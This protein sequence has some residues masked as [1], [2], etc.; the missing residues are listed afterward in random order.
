MNNSRKSPSSPSPRRRPTAKSTF[1]THSGSDIKLNRSLGD[2]VRAGRDAKARRRA[3]HLSKLPK[4]RWKRLLYRLHPKHLAEYWF[5]RD[6]AIMALKLFGVGIVVC[7]ILLVGVFAYFRKDLPNPKDISVN[8]G[9]IGGTISYYARDGKT[10]LWQDYN[11][12]NRIPVPGNQISDKLRQATVAVEDKDFYKHGAFDVRGILRAGFSDLLHSGGGLQGGST[13]TQQLVKLNEGWT[14]DQTIS[15][16]IKEIILAVDLEREYSKADILTGYL[17]TA[18][19]SPVDDGA[20]TA[21]QDYFGI[22]PKDLS[23]PQAAMLAAIPK[24]PN[25]YSPYG[26][27]FDSQALISRQH[28]I[29]D[30]M[31]AQ[32]MISKSD[33]D[34]AKAVDILAQVKPQQTQYSNI[35]DPYFVM[36]AKNQLEQQYGE[37]TVRRGGW[38]V[39]T[40]LDPSLQADAEKL[41]ASNLPNV[42]RYGG[43]EEAMVGEQVQTGQVVMLVGGVSFQDPDHG[44][45]NY[46]QINLSPGSSFKPYDYAS[47]IND[48]TNSG[49]GSVLYDVKGSVT[50]KQDGGYACTRPTLPPTNPQADCL[51]DYDL[52][53]PGPLTLRYALAGSR[54][55][56]AIK[57]ML[58]VGTQ[59]VI[60]TANSMMG[61]NDAYK[62]FERGANVET[63]GPDQ[64]SRCYASSGIGDGAYL[65]LDNHVNGLAT[66]GRLGSAIPQ[67]YILGITDAAGKN[68]YTWKQP[69]G[70]QVVRPDAA[71]IVDN[72]LSD[73]NASYLPGSYKFQH[74]KGWN[75][76]VKTGTTNDNFDGLMTSW[77]TQYAVASWVGYHTRN[78]AMTAGGM[79][80]MTTPLTRSWMEEA[81]DALGVKDP[82]KLNWQ[83][84]AD[85]QTLPSFIVSSGWGSGAVLNSPQNAG[86][87]IFPSWY[88][89]P[90]AGA[91]Q[92]ID[93]VSGN[94][95]TSC[96][97]QLARKTQGGNF[98]VSA[99]S[100]DIFFNA[101]GSAAANVTAN[102][103]VH[104][105]GDT[106]P[107]VSVT[108]AQCDSPGKCDFTVVVTQGTDA[109]TGAY[110]TSPAST[111]SLSVNGQVV[112]SQPIPAG[113]GANGTP[114]QTTFSGVSVTDGQSV[115]AQAV[116]SVLYSGNSTITA[117]NTGGSGGNN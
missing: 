38:K 88:V 83:Q 20:Q 36:A 24:S 29:L 25:V 117:S 17:N 80:Y 57:A 4:N 13:I 58:T 92:T 40:T 30:Q 18:P 99:F 78:K 81:H 53:F 91:P 49:A 48:T 62:C 23:L 114:Y 108:Q 111:V 44:Q 107:S 85:I 43:D 65:H 76:A 67:T 2:R 41:V 27:L 70:K 104:N 7:F 46:A 64:E 94:L 86:K 61:V 19:Y 116:D 9:N 109:L 105:C 71:Y 47:L 56:P 106:S 16:K 28:Y 63:A 95:A 84:P 15:R 39:I 93:V 34:A 31:V 5:S 75:F 101:S 26:S 14:A 68:V 59:K 11:A 42:Q 45:I 89:A 74:Y 77:S 60:D 97:P 10:L 22:S 73:P 103:N 113:A 52:R 51:Y 69:Q 35:Q 72:M 115:Q 112:A 3:A 6:G 79:E 96:T 100:A 37:Q 54:N 12:V 66:L 32:K 1:T 110:N 8:G 50:T 21:A 98:N 82:S 90:K 87:D 33:A 55:V 102:D